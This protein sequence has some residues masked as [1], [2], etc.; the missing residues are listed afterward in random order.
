MFR[1]GLRRLLETETDIAVI[2]E[3][4]NGRA[5]VTLA[6]ELCPDIVIMDIAMPSLNGI[7]A[8]RQILAASPTAKILILSAH[9]DDAYIQRVLSMGAAGYLVKNSTAEFLV[10]AIRVLHAGGTTFSPT[11]ARRLQA[12]CT[13]A[14]TEQSSVAEL[15]R[16]TGREVEV[17]QLVAEGN[18]NKQVAEVLGISIKT[19]EKHRQNIMDKLGIHDTA[20]LTRY[21]IVG[22]IIKPGEGSV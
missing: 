21:A 5:A 17:L 6:A 9:S 12:S 16:L 18:A 2:G 15:P 11:V 3:S 10:K 7:E 20:G 19:V 1:A 13:S 8:T 4:S 22:G 14:A